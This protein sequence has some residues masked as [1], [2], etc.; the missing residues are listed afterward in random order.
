[1]ERKITDRDHDKYITSPEFNTRKICCKIIISKFARKSYITNFEEK[2]DFADNLTDVNKK[3]TS[4]KTKHVLVENE[5]KKYRQ[6]TQ[7]LLLVKVTLIIMEQN[8]S[9][10]IYQFLTKYFNQS[11]KLLQHF[12]NCQMKNLGALM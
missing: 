5:F 6:L 2:T 8:F 12:L 11:A 9:T 7:V 10:N 4:N 3:V 1:M